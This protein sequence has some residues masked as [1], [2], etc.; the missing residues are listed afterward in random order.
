MPQS[1]GPAGCS[2]LSSF[3][4]VGHPRVASPHTRIGLLRSS[5]TVH[6]DASGE[7]LLDE[8]G[9]VE[10]IGESELLPHARAHTR[11]SAQ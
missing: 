4:F 6:G 9:E 5:L 10:N 3:G 7:W 1:A 8:N 2:A 11:N